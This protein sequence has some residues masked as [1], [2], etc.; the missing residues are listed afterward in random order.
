MKNKPWSG[1]QTRL[2]DPCFIWLHINPHC[3]LF[4]AVWSGPQ[5]FQ[6]LPWEAAGCLST[7]SSPKAS[8][9][10]WGSRHTLLCTQ[11]RRSERQNTVYLSVRFLTKN[12]ADK[13]GFPPAEQ[14][15]FIHRTYMPGLCP[16]THVI[17]KSQSLKTHKRGETCHATGLSAAFTTAS[18]IANSVGFRKEAAFLKHLPRCHFLRHMRSVSSCLGS[19]LPQR[20]AISSLDWQIQHRVSG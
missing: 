2:F 6:S 14:G 18:A 5:Y 17:C 4:E 7:N 9:P 16:E 19:L 12:W 3:L 10:V 13:S 11:G 15:G 20:V 8:Q 1:A